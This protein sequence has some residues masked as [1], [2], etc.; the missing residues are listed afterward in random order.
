M[1]LKICSHFIES[2]TSKLLFLWENQKQWWI[3]GWDFGKIT[4]NLIGVGLMIPD[5]KIWKEIAIGKNQW[6]F[7]SKLKQS[8]AEPWLE[9]FRL[10]KS[11][12]QYD[13]NQFLK[14]RTLIVR[15]EDI[16]LDELGMAEKIY[17]FVGLEMHPKVRHMI[18][19]NDRNSREEKSKRKRRA[20]TAWEKVALT[21]DLNMFGELI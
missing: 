20:A 12:I 7:T 3:Q 6:T 2:L 13:D 9:K 1:K 5:S 10:F 15:F 4:W 19:M 17:N 21:R 8:S 18:L 11:K 16:V 14:N